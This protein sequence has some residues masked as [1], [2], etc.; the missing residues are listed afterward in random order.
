MAAYVTFTRAQWRL[1]LLMGLAATAV[2]GIAACGKLGLGGSDEMGWARAALER[3]DRIEVVASDPTANTF[4]VRI[5]STGDL[6][7]LKVDQIIAGPP[8]D[9]GDAGAR[10]HPGQHSRSDRGP[11]RKRYGGE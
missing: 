4:T 5:K 6:Q 1:P 7:V 9:P 11:R 2:L 8:G 10:K 3:N